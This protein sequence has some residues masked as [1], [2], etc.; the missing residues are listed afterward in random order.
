MRNTHESVLVK[1]EK[2]DYSEGLGIDGT[3]IK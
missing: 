2:K 3:V 1:P